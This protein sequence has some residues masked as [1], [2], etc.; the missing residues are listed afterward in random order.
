M[1]KSKIQEIGYAKNLYDVKN[2]GRVCYPARKGF[3]EIDM[4]EYNYSSVL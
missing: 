1:T 2:H 3:T 4:L